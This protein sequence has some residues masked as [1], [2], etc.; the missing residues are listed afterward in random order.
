MTDLVIPTRRKE[1][2]LSTVTEVEDAAW[3][4]LNRQF[5]HQLPPTD[6]GAPDYWTLRSLQA[7]RKRENRQNPGT[8]DMSIWDKEKFGKKTFVGFVAL[9][10]RE[11]DVKTAEIGWKIARQYQR[12]G[13]AATAAHA[14]IDY[15]REELEVE[16]IV[17][18]VKPGN[19]AAVGLVEY[20]GFE[21]TEAHQDSM[22]FTQR[23]TS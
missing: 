20:L 21:L 4:L 5:T 17:A 19:H 10:P 14:I 18:K 12:L 15:A 22:L 2:Y 7:E 23:T 11:A 3:L 9:Y 6:P 16:S 1:V 13:Y 8:L